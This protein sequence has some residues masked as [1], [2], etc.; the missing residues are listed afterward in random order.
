MPPSFDAEAWGVEPGYVDVDGFWRE[1]PPAS[2]DAVLRAM[3]ATADGPP[4][5]PAP[6]PGRRPARCPPPPATRAWGWATQLYAVRS[7]A[8]WG[9][10]DLGDLAR[11]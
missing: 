10:G 11:L 6:A 4:P 3:G 2:V 9:I 7:R 1:A 8:S 5:A